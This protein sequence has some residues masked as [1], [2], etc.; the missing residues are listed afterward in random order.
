MFPF[1]SAQANLST[2]ETY[3]DGCS[4]CVGAFFMPRPLQQQKI[5]K[6]SLNRILHFKICIVQSQRE[7]Q[8]VS[9]NNTRSGCFYHSGIFLK[10]S[11]LTLFIIV[12]ICI[13]TITVNTFQ[14]TLFF[15]SYPTVAAWAINPPSFWITIDSYPCLF[16]LLKNNR[17]CCLLS[18]WYKTMPKLPLSTCTLQV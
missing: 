6:S 2:S 4:H 5:I 7:N 9:T 10:M 17:C 12:F 16:Y 11:S 18:V 15:S 8:W 13:S 3:L 1:D 14:Q